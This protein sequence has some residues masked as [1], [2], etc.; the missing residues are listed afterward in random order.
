MDTYTT[1][2]N[3]N[4]PARATAGGKELCPS[5]KL[6]GDERQ[7]LALRILAGAPS[8]SK[9]AAT[10]CVSRKFLYQ[11]SRKA[12][13]AMDEAFVRRDDASE[14]LFHL[15]VTAEWLDQFILGQV[16]ICHASF[17]GVKEF[18]RDTLGV[19]ISIGPVHNV[20]MEAVK[21]ARASNAAERLANVKVGAHDEIFQARQPVL[22]GAD[23]DSTW[24]YLLSSE[25]SRDG[26]TWALRLMELSDKN[27]RPDYTVADGGKGLRAGH[28]LAWPSVPCRGDVFHSLLEMRR[29]AM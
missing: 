15:P 29:P 21:R 6:R 16:L 7:E 17:R 2:T 18:M 23:V 24:C 1:T 27:L 12:E 14:V 4:A 5:A 20:V 19:P 13:T 22:V 11:Q 28:T 26:D 8:I 9:L 25:N 3:A 10:N